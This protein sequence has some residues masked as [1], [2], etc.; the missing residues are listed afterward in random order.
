MRASLSHT[1]SSQR[2]SLGDPA[3]PVLLEA[4]KFGQPLLGHGG[5]RGEIF[6]TWQ[7]DGLDAASPAS[8]CRLTARSRVCGPVARLRVLDRQEQWLWLST[9]SRRAL[10]MPGTRSRDLAG[11]AGRQNLPA[12]T[13]A[14]ALPR[15]CTGSADFQ[16]PRHTTCC[17]LPATAV[18][19][20]GGLSNVGFLCATSAVR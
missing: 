6:C 20:T 1:V 3:L 11:R 19:M 15:G 8:C 2:G 7:W 10:W 5:L 9:W 18:R 16:K 14:S 17:V 4:G 13:M 12:A